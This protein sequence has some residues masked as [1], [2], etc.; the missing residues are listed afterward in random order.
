MVRY[1][2]FSHPD[3][4]TSESY[5]KCPLIPLFFFIKWFCVASINRE[6]IWKSRRKRRRGWWKLRSIKASVEPKKWSNTRRSSIGRI[7]SK[8]SVTGFVDLEKKKQLSCVVPLAC[9]CEC[10]LDGMSACKTKGKWRK[11]KASFLK[12]LHAFMYD[13]FYE[14]FD[15]I[16]VF[17]YVYTWSF[18]ASCCFHLIGKHVQSDTYAKRNCAVYTAFNLME[19]TFIS[20]V[21]EL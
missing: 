19:F 6:K 11:L 2:F 18:L 12:I 16:S 9:V 14:F 3:T 15:L 21:N 8:K 20:H 17:G 4:Y 5:W 13:P 10:R 7:S 1:S